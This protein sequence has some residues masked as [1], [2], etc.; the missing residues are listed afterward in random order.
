LHLFTV[1]VVVHPD[2]DNIPI[3]L[4]LIK[5]SGDESIE[6][7]IILTVLRVPSAEFVEEL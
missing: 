2:S 3:K 1:K 5:I 4:L 6:I 7:S